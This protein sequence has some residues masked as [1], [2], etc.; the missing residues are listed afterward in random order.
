MQLSRRRGFSM[1]ELLTTLIIMGI[2]AGL[3]VPRID[4]SRLRSDAALRQITTLMVQAQRTALSKQSNVIISVD[5]PNSRL[6]L[7]EDR[8]NSNT[9]DAGDR[10]VW[11]ALEPGVKF[12]TA[13]APLDGLS[14]IVTFARP[15]LV[16]SYPSVIFRRN[17][18]A[19]SD[20]VMFISSKPSDIGATRG[21][22]ITQSTGRALGFKYS[23]TVWVQAGA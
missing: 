23:G 19:S 21:V 12:V 13:P 5:A 9:Y 22:T 17:G 16:D 1:V 6:R 10:M 15:R 14:G 7:V 18:A 2:I 4:M 3:A 20:G 8:N 11:M